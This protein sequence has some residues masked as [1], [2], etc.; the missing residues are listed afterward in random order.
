M[1][2]E[3]VRIR[4]IMSGRGVETD[5][6]IVATVIMNLSKK[7]VLGILPAGIKIKKLSFLS[8]QGLCHRQVCVKN[9]SMLKIRGSTDLYLL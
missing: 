9:P 4:R 5:K 3:P 1:H 7:M 8:E 6:T 2:E